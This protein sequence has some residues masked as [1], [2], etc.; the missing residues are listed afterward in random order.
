LRATAAFGHKRP[1]E[2][3]PPNVRFPIRKET[4]EPIAAAQNDLFV[5]YVSFGIPKWKKLTGSDFVAF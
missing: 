4:F 2:G 1:F 3:A 5:G